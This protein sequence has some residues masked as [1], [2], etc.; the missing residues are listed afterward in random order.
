[1]ARVSKSIAIKRLEKAGMEVS[2]FDTTIY[3]DGDCSHCGARSKIGELDVSDDGTV[4]ARHLEALITEY[5][6]RP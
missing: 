2:D 5:E 3:A 1:M 4:D 6:G